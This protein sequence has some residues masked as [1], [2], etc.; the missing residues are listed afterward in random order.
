MAGH[1][2]LHDAK[3]L[4]YLAGRESIRTGPHQEPECSEARVVGQG[5]EYIDRGF[6]I[7]ISRILDIWMLYKE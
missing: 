5:F 2:V 1:R 4:C 6:S 7:H 3:L